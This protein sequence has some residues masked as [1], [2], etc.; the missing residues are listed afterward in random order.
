MRNNDLIREFINGATTGK[1]SNLEI[2]GQE[3]VNYTTT[4]A[5]RTH[6]GD[7]LLNRHDYSRT[8]KVHQNRIAYETPSRLLAE[9]PTEESFKEAM[10]VSKYT[11]SQ[12][13]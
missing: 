5:F 7:I 8:T 1:G 3:L 11:E 6:K 9:I 4:I 13:E 12:G 2:K 10:R